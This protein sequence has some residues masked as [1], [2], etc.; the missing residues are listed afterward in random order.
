MKHNFD[1]HMAMARVI[2]FRAR[3]E[4][5]RANRWP[6]VNLDAGAERQRLS[7]IDPIFGHKVSRTTDS[8]NISLPASYEVDLWGRLSGLESAARA[9]LLKEEENLQVVAQSIVAETVSRYIQLWS[10]VRRQDYLQETVATLKDSLET[11]ERRY[12]QGLAKSL[13]VRQARRTL[14]QAEA[15]LPVIADELVKVRHQLAVLAGRYPNLELFQGADV[16]DYDK[17]PP[18]PPGLPAQ[19]L[20]RRPDIRAAEAELLALH[21]E[22]GAAYASRFPRITLTGSLGYASHELSEL[23]KPES[24]FWRL[25]AG[26]VQPLIDGGRLKADQEIAEARF[27]QAV[28]GYAKT[29][30]VAFA[31]VEASL[32]SRRSLLDR[33]QRL[34]TLVREAQ[35]TLETARKRYRQGLMDYLAVLDAQKVLI[36]SR[37]DL[38]EADQALYQNRINLYRALGGG[39]AHVSVN[40]LSSTGNKKTAKVEE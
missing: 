40:N 35:A 22:V 13:D 27:R 29:V 6:V 17:L 19:L 16:L 8:F 34:A 5:A 26:I 30:L 15:G 24:W 21:S 32:A 38:V 37:L 12:S 11:V 10:L 33:R 9:R 28:A 20:S 36:T 39:W 1:L 3:L 14:A 23:L 25:A 31:E 18:V 7:T 2:E 4:R